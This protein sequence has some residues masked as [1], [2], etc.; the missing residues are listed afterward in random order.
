MDGWH[1]LSHV[2]V[3]LL[4]W[5]AYAYV[6]YKNG[7]TAITKEH[8]ILSLSAFGSSIILL[9]VTLFMVVESIHK[10]AKPNLNVGYEA[11]LVALIGLV[12]NGFSAF[13]L[14]REE[15]KMDLN[16][17]AAYIHV[18]SDVLLS[19]LA[20]LSLFAARYFAINWMDPVCGLVGAAIILK[21][22]VELIHKS[23][24]ELLGN[25]EI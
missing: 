19:V 14:H 22:A 10:F 13:F 6:K 3:I 1:M 17:R 20:I 8:Q 24:G 23:W 15:E 7:S 16:L 12:V 25:R 2:L 21:W 18:L 11:L 9:L 5:L 4:A